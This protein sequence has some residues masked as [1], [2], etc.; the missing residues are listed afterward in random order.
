MLYEAYTSSE[1]HK[2]RTQEAERRATENYR[3][4]NHKTREQVVLTSVVTSILGLFV[5]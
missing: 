5:R 4:R 1:V 3:F 2:M